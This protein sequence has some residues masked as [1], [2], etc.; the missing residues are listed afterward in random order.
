MKMSECKYVYRCSNCGLSAEGG[1]IYCG[2]TKI[3][4]GRCRG[5]NGVHMSLDRRGQEK[6]RRLTWKERF[7]GF[8][9]VEG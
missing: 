5:C 7:A 9:K 8:I 3:G 6:V 1:D 2:E 4:T